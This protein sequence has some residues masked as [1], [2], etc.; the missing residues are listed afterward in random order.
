MRQNWLRVAIKGAIL[1]SFSTVCPAQNSLLDQL[2]EIDTRVLSDRTGEDLEAMLAEHAQK[3]ILEANRKSSM[4]WLAIS[5]PHEWEAYVQR[6][7]EALDDSLG[8]LPDSFGPPNVQISN[9]LDGDGFKI[10]N[11]VFESRPG[12]WVTANLY[13]PDPMRTSMPGIILCHSHHNP[14]TQGELQD[15]G[16]TWARLGC[17]VLVMDQVGHGE[18]SD[19]PFHSPADYPEEFAVGRQDY[20]FRYNLGIQL[21][22][23]GDS[24]IGWMVHDLRR[25]VDL[26]LSRDGVD[27]KRIILMGSV[28]GGGNPAA[29]AAALDQR[30]S[31]AVP[32]NFGGPEPET[33]YPLP[34]DAGETFNYAGSGSWESTRNLRL[35]CR[36]GFLPW[37]IVA[38]IA[39]RPLVYAHEFSWDRERDPVWKRLRRVYEDFYQVADH[40][41]FTHGFGLLQQRPPDA[42]HCNNIGPFQRKR[43]YTALHR[44]FGIA[45]PEEEYSKR[46]DTQEL[47]CSTEDTIRRFKPKKLHDLASEVGHARMMKTHSEMQGLPPQA[48]RE[49]LRS[50]WKELLGEVDPVQKAPIRTHRP[51]NSGGLW[52]EKSVLEVEPGILVPFVLLGASDGQDRKPVVVCLAQSGKA[53]L[54]EERAEFIAKLVAGGADVCLIDVRG[55]GETAVPGGRG[56]TSRSTSVSST[57]LMLGQTVVGSQL[58]DLRSVMEYL[59]KHPRVDPEK[60]AVFGD[61][62]ARDNRAGMNLAVPM[63]IE[64]EPGLSEP[65]GGILALLGAL[66]EEHLSAV[67]IGHGLLSYAS[68]LSTPFCYLPHDA[69]VPGALEAGDLQELAAACY[70]TPMR[71]EGLVDGQNVRVGER[72][73]RDSYEP[74]VDAYKD[75]ADHFIL[76]AGQSEPDAVTAW[77]LKRFE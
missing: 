65:L 69:V 22:L 46:R 1:I 32:F 7:L 61:S 66:F 2:R 70:P 54:L 8:E 25:G 21:H 15:M 62:L 58:R 36:D 31:A 43:I 34:E 63:G 40:L 48:R 13:V 56:R 12:F 28:A 42:S 37:V 51:E 10:L 4:E 29:V 64:S 18:R 45:V 26:L 27:P 20:Y 49:R 71:I 41:D 11:L 59:R 60:I 16:M 68:V 57:E 3:R 30:I 77:M 44:W 38:G 76:R 33:V 23:I 6:R 17:Q 47:R 74:V 73:A 5:E 19:H 67:Y 52:I 9:T 39:P 24:L 75:L 53:R 14:K 50:I 55:T 72:E 35:S